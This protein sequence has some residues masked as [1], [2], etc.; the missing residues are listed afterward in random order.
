[1]AVLLEE[2]LEGGDVARLLRLLV[3]HELGEA[4]GGDVP[5]PLQRGD[6]SAPERADLIA[7][8]ALLPPTV[9]ERLVA[10]WD[11]YGRAE[12]PEARVAKGLDRLETCLEYDRPQE[13]EGGP[14]T[15]ILRSPL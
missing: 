7:I 9:R 6:K 10:L 3:M 12:G 2:Q 8:L 4:V 1:M 13:L 15:G 5:A 11:E 14:C